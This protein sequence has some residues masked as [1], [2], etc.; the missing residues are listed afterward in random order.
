MMLPGQH[1]DVD[2]LVDRGLIGPAYANMV[3]TNTIQASLEEIL[4]YQKTPHPWRVEDND[5]V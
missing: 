4:F 5:A 2:S 3:K 1:E